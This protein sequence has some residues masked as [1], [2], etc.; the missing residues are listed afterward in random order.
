MSPALAPSPAP[1][2]DGAPALAPVAWDFRLPLREAEFHAGIADLLHAAVNGTPR[3]ELLASLCAHLARLLR[4]PLAVIA[5]RVDSGT[6]AVEAESA[7][8]AL[9]LELQRIPERWDGGLSGQGPA[10]EALR[11]GSA[12]QM[13]PHHDG[14]ALWRAAAQ[15]EGV[16][17]VLAIPVTA[18]GTTYVVE[19]CFDGEIP[20]GASAATLTVGRLAQALRRFL[21]DL[22]TIA[23]RALVA[24]ALACAGNAAFITDVE[25]TIVWS[26]PAFSALSGYSADEVRGRNPNLLRSGRQ[27]LRYYRELW[28]TIRAGKVWSGETIDRAK[29]GNEYAIQQTVSPVAQDE[30]ITHYVS[31]HEDI[32]RERRERAALE[33]ASH[34]S[35]D[36]G[37][38]TRAAFEDAAA[39]ACAD[40][41]GRPLAVVVVVLRGLQRAAAALGE[42]MEGLLRAALGRRVRDAVPQPDLAGSTAP[43]EYILLLRGDVSEARVAARLQTLREQLAEP[44][45]YLGA[46]PELDFQSGSARLPDHGAT[47]QELLLK[48]D[49]QLANEPFRPASRAAPN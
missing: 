44:L 41:G 46:I 12:V 13:H 43:F 35:P 48:A 22:D 30:R 28:A 42:E 8:G 36:T 24:R 4:L 49:R 21:E 39:K 7:E 23:Q 9:W 27:G 25:G 16:Q 40:A 15:A 47:L 34:L 1:S 18:A 2:A 29:D 33:L 6:M 11:A 17:R 14:F 38:L 10:A 32:G 5:R 20:R 45:P 19:L 26:N 31:I 37:L 3:R